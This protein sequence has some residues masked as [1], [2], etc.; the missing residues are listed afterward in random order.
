MVVAFAISVAMFGTFFFFS[1][2]MQLIRGYSALQT[3]IRILPITGMIFFV[4]PQAGRWAQ[5]HGSRAAMTVG[6]LLAGSGCTLHHVRD[7]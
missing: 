3:G 5:K 6:P 2:Y 1:L 4:A 7:T